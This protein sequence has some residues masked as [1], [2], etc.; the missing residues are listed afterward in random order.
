MRAERHEY[1]EP[2]QWIPAH[3]LVATTLMSSGILTAK[4]VSVLDAVSHTQRSA[5]DAIQRESSP[6][7]GV[8]ASMCPLLGRAQEQPLHRL[9]SE[10]CSRLCQRT[11]SD[12]TRAICRG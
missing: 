7:I 5:V 2:R 11:R 9:C 10:S 12:G 8:C 3:A 1:D 6:A 4:V